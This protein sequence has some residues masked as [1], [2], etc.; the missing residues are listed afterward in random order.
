MEPIVL[1]AAMP[2][3]L[4]FVS[5]YKTSLVEVPEV[6]RTGFLWATSTCLVIGC[7]HQD[8]G[9]TEIT[10]GLARDVG[11]AKGLIFDG[12]IKLLTEH[13][14]LEQVGGAILAETRIPRAEVRIR[15]WTD[16]ETQSPFVVVGIE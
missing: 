12:A 15:V 2:N 8:F 14:V 3:G 13:L 7:E 4:L 1:R 6:G 5:D 11:L 9:E 16:G 10:F